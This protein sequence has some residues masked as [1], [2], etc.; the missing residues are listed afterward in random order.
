MPQQE[1]ADHLEEAH[2]GEPGPGQH[3]QDVERGNRARRHEDPGDDAQ[4]TEGDPPGPSLSGATGGPPCE[5]GHPLDD[6]GDP[7]HQADQRPAQ[8]QVA[9]EHDAQHDEQQSGDDQPDPV[10]VRNGE[11]TD[12]VEDTRN[13]HKD[14]QQDRDHVQRP[15]RVKAHDEPENQ[16]QRAEEDPCLPRPGRGH[17]R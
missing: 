16:R 5:L 13:D 10:G 1:A 15:R 7:D 2:D 8:M 14:A 17:Q 9:D 12:Q 11:H 6:K 4:R 3:G